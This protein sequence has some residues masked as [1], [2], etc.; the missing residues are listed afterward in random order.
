MKNVN[1]DS[2]FV[3][4]LPFLKINRLVHHGHSATPLHRDP[5]ISRLLDIH[6]YPTTPLLKK[7]GT[8]T[9]PVPEI[10][11]RSTISLLE[12]LGRPTTSVPETHG[13]LTNSP[14]DHHQYPK[15]PLRQMRFYPS[16][17]S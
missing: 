10:R 8:P 17:A 15:T 9:T 5:Q 16:T 14:L 12:H 7:H 13:P 11:G 2:T 6:G 3:K 1:Q 4:L